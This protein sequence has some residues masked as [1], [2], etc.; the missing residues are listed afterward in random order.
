MK[1]AVAVLEADARAREHDA[2]NRAVIEAEVLQALN[3][4]KREAERQKRL[5][6]FD[7]W[8]RKWDEL[9][10]VS[11]EGSTVTPPTCVPTRG[12]LFVFLS[13]SIVYSY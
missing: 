5:K 2:I 9:G 7:E 4:K 3:E 11:L 6:K 12:C 13:F 1:R 10:L 8:K